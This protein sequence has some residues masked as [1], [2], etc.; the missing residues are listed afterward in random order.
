MKQFSLDWN[1]GAFRRSCE[2]RA[3]G[4]FQVKDNARARAQDNNLSEDKIN[5]KLR[6]WECR[7]HIGL[8]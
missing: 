4:I 6:G 7:I 1:N 5:E 8:Q 2:S 3:E